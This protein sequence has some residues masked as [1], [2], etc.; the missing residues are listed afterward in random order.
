MLKGKPP[1][2]ASIVCPLHCGGR[3]P[4]S[5]ACATCRPV[6]VLAVSPTMACQTAS[7]E[8]CVDNPALVRRGELAAHS[9]YICRLCG[10]NGPI[11]T[12]FC[13]WNVM[14]QGH[15]ERRWTTLSRR[16]SQ[17]GRSW[18]A[19]DYG[20]LQTPRGYLGRCAVKQ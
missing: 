7:L 2:C 14:C 18:M 8:L 17:D 9:A 11:E 6:L 1:M 20:K 15:A 16:L 19:D 3:G 4:Q 12:S 13:W 5:T 10:H